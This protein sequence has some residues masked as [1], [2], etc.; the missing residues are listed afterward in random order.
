MALQK[1][2]LPILTFKRG[3]NIKSVSQTPALLVCQEVNTQTPLETF[4]EN[5][6]PE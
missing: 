5:I 4:K 3:V 6:L 1:W 2:Q